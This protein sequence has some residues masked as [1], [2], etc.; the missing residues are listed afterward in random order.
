MA[1]AFYSWPGIWHGWGNGQIQALAP[2]SSLLADPEL[3][4]RAEYS[5]RIFLGR[6]LAGGWLHEY[7]FNAGR[8][9]VF[10]QIAYDIRTA[11]LGLL[12]LHQATGNPEYALLAGIAASWLTG[13]NVAGQPLYDAATGRGYDGIDREGVNRNAGAESTIEALFTLIEIEKV[14][15]AT[16]WLQARSTEKLLENFP[17]PFNAGTRISWQLPETGRGSKAEYS[18]SIYDILGRKVRFLPVNTKS[19]RG[20]SCWDGRDDA[21]AAVSGGVYLLVLEG[22]GQRLVRKVLLLR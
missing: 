22:G 19:G 1:G 10:A 13:N 4:R 16:A 20:E 18:L 2:L 11:A 14:P 12:A 7:D 5:G 17:N 21:A 9:A 8:A 6:M 3:L 15:A